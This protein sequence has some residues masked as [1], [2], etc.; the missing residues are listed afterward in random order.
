MT[1]FGMRLIPAAVGD[2]FGG[3][4][5]QDPM[6]RAELSSTRLWPKTRQRNASPSQTTESATGRRRKPKMRS[7]TTPPA[8][9]MP[10]QAS[11]LA[12][13]VFARRSQKARLIAFAMSEP[14]QQ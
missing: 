4:L 8:F 6:A 9:P 7:R 11:F 13:A 2:V 1:G 10:T 5:S 3:S 12:E 14:N